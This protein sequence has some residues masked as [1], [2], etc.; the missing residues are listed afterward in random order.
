[1][2]SV[3][4]QKLGSDRPTRPPIRTMAS[5]RE[6]GRVAE[7]SPSGMPTAIAMSAAAA[8][9]SIVAGSR[10]AISTKTGRPVRIE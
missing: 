5:M 9:S 4:S 6:R 8:A 2:I 1:M 3:P 10:S 7:R